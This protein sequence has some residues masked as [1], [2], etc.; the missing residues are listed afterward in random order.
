MYLSKPG[1]PRNGD[2]KILTLCID[3]IHP[4]NK[5]PHEWSPARRACPAVLVENDILCEV[6]IKDPTKI[7]QP[8]LHPV[9]PNQPQ[10]I[11]YK[12]VCPELIGFVCDSLEENWE[13]M[14][15]FRVGTSWSK[16]S[17]YEIVI[18]VTPSTLHEWQTPVS[19]SSTGWPHDR[20]RSWHLQ[21]HPSLR[22]D[23]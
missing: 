17:P 3:A 13:S 16:S 1:Y 14:S 7:F 4:D 23:T 8:S 22:R 10:V 11:A 18:I 20:L 2:G 6:E 12:A 21:R 15:L 9:G 19:S 5:D